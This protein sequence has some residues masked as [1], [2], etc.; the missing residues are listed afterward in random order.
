M[1]A[2]DK[3]GHLKAG[4]MAAVFGLAVGAVLAVLMAGVLALEGR[5]VRAAVLVGA[6]LG[7][8]VS[9]AAAGITKELADK[10]DNALQPGSH[11]VELRDA[12]ATAAPGALA[13][14]ACCLLAYSSGA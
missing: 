3:I 13:C 1:M 5:G 4:A 11:L 14:A 12:L 7:A 2:A 9:A 8:L 10:A 6:G